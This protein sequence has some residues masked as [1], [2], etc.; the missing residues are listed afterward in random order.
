MS[1]WAR[2]K[3]ELGRETQP[4]GTVV[5]LIIL[6]RGLRSI[7]LFILGI[8]LLTRSR[9]ILRLVRH[10]VAELDLN[11]GRG[12][13]QH[14]LLAVLRPIGLLPSRTVILIALGT[15]AFAALEMTEAVGLARRRRWAEYLTALAGTIGIPLEIHEVLVRQT[16]L[17]ISFLVINVAIVVY[18]AWQKHLF[19]LRGGVGTELDRAG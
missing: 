13:I 8:A 4:V 2:L 6:E 17:R 18:L 11:G 1:F 14:L 16:P 7:L 3:R 12:V 9:V 19:G 5:R 15:L 10:Y